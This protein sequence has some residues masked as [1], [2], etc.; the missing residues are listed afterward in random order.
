MALASPKIQQ[1]IQ[2]KESQPV[3]LSSLSKSRKNTGFIKCILFV[4][5]TLDVPFSCDKEL[6]IHQDLH[7]LEETMS[8]PCQFGRGR[9]SAT[10]FARKS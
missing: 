7:F 8:R 3:T 2:A 1:L 4:E 10:K 9:L 5:C 6:D